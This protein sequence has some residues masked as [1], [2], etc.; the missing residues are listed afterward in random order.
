MKLSL[1]L[2]KEVSKQTTRHI[3]QLARKAGAQDVQPLFADAPLPE[4]ARFYIVDVPDTLAGGVIQTLS[5]V[6]GV[7]AIERSAKR[8]PT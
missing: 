4:L 2:S 1:T 5:G 3:V 8:R 6:N 7:E